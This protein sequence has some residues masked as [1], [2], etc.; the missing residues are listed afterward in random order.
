MASIK[1]LKKDIN[2][3]TD[4]V[5]GTCLLHQYANQDKNQQKVDQLIDE[6]LEA[7]DEMINKVNH[8]EQRPE[9]TSVKAYYNELFG[10]YLQKVN[11]AF[12][13]LGNLEE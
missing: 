3:L 12:D 1:N 4:E 10:A 8:P 5:I 9:G 6:M 7:R 2:F 11:D 13:T